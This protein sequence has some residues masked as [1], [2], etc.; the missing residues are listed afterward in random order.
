VL[1]PP[2]DRAQRRALLRAGFLP[3][4]KR[5]RFVGKALHEGAHLETRGDAW[6]FTLGDFDFF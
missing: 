6:H 1:L 2:R 5:L 4:N 3:T